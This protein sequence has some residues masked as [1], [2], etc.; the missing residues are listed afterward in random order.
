MVLIILEINT[1]KSSNNELNYESNN[2]L[3][4]NALSE[5][6]TTNKTKCIIITKTKSNSKSINSRKLLNNST[7]TINALKY[8]K[9]HIVNNK[10]LTKRKPETPTNCSFNSES[11]TINSST[12]KLNKNEN[13]NKQNKSS[14]STT[15][16][17]NDLLSPTNVQNDSN[18]TNTTWI[19]NELN[20]NKLLSKSTKSQ[21][22]GN[23]VELLKEIDDTSTTN[24]SDNELNDES[25]NKSSLTITIQII[26]EQIH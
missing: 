10:L 1:F 14:L 17:F 19:N 6:S 20:L 23:D 13:K 16:N 9:L 7:T 24:Q 2:K 18:S 11:I 3:I 26:Q 4:Q 21:T 15:M 12:R 5:L 8:N 22:I 25:N